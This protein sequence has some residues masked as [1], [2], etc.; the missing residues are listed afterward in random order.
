MN[1]LDQFPEDLAREVYRHLS[2]K[3]LL[4]LHGTKPRLPGLACAIAERKKDWI[5][6]LTAVLKEEHRIIEMWPGTLT[7]SFKWEGVGKGIPEMPS[8]AWTFVRKGN[9]VTLF[10]STGK[11]TDVVFASFVTTDGKPGSSFFFDIDNAKYDA[12]YFKCMKLAWM[13]LKK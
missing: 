9:T 3:D 5:D 2:L 7:C 10:I 4:A 1:F 13:R 12:V 6:A 8:Y 11:P